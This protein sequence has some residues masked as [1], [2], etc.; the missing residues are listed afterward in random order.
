MSTENYLEQDRE[1]RIDLSSNIPDSEKTNGWKPIGAI[2][3][4]GFIG[5]VF[6]LEG[7]R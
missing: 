4:S 6:K 5:L 7:I 3:I 2:A 1:Q